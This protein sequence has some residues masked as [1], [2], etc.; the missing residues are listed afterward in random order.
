[1]N[2]I[3]SKDLPIQLATYFTY[4]K[5]HGVRY[6]NIYFNG[7][8]D[9][10]MFEEFNLIHHTK[11]DDDFRVINDTEQ[12]DVPDF[13]LKYQDLIEDIA[14][15]YSKSY[16]W[17]NNDGGYGDFYLNID[18][19]EYMTEYHIYYTQTESYIEAGHVE[20]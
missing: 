10:G 11:M 9:S 3:D 20:I 18:T 12:K 14:D 13:D 6:I 2:I 5:D 17:W 7:G 1:M 15:K 8:G 16:D 4:L 19:L